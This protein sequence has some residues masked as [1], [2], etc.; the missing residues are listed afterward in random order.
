MASLVKVT[1]RPKKKT[2]E[3]ET[4]WRIN[5]QFA[6]EHKTRY[7][8]LGRMSKKQARDIKSKVEFLIVAKDTGTSDPDALRWAAKLRDELHGRL[9]SHGLVERR[10][11]AEIKTLKAMLDNFIAKRKTKKHSTLIVYGHTRRCLIEYFGANKPIEQVTPADAKDWRQWLGLA[12]NET[13]S[14]A[15]GQGLSEN[16]VRR[17]CGIARQFFTDAVERRL[18]AENPFAKM[19]SVAVRPNRTRDYFVTR[20]EA[21]AV[22]KACPDNQWRLIFALS[23]Y[24]GLRCPSE[25]LAL[26]WGDVDFENGRINVKSPKTE[27]HE[28]HEERTAPL[29]AE[30]RPYL[31]AVHGELLASNFDPKQSPMSKQPVITRY[32]D[33]NANLRTQLCK[34]IRR[35]GLKPWPKLFQNLRATR[36]TELADQFPS[37]VSADW[38]GHSTTIADKHYRQTT[39]EHFAK[40]VGKLQ[41][42]SPAGGSDEKAHRGA[43]QKGTQHIGMGG[44]GQEVPS[45]KPVDFEF[46]PT[47]LVSASGRHWTRTSDLC[48]VN[49]AL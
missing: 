48:G 34:I 22:L 12:K 13:D 18:I 27:H 44:Q 32:R 8:R 19:K 38:L 17:R 1:G 42:A 31:E 47:P 21:D 10:T 6:D 9:A 15:G 20:D 5:F 14:D 24:G 23:R 49:T 36:A 29:F 11:E 3:C 43:H 4:T 16:T 46:C 25:H 28:G 7:I 2:G 33:T 37:H 39:S 41:A 30:L 35:A 26:T 45:E 40:A